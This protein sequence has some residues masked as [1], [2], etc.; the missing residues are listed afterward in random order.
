MVMRVSA[1]AINGEAIAIGRIVPRGVQAPA[2]W[3]TSATLGSSPVLAPP[4]SNP[5][6]LPRCFG[7]TERLR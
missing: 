3:A 6:F 1:M 4:I 2:A 5:K 7:G